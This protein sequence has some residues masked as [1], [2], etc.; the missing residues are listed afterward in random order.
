MIQSVLEVLEEWNR[1][2]KNLAIFSFFFSVDK[3]AVIGLKSLLEGKSP[4]VENPCSREKWD[5]CWR[6]LYAAP[7]PDI[8]ALYN[9]IQSWV[10]S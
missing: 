7:V 4:V 5:Y 1:L 8:V 3:F 2:Q 9:V 6:K 10:T